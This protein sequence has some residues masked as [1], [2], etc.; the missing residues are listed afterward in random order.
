MNKRW[1]LLLLVLST[2]MPL[3]VTAATLTVGTASIQRLFVEGV[4][5]KNGRW[6]LQD[7]V[8][9]AYLDS[10]RTW[11]AGGRVHIEA[12]LSS[13]LGVEMSGSCV[14]NPLAS[15][16]EMSG[17]LVGA[18]TTLSLAD[19]KIDRI[20]DQA[21]GS[22]LDLLQSMV[23]APPPVDVLSTIRDR[24]ADSDD[25]P[26]SVDTLRIDSVTTSDTEVTIQFDF[27]VRAP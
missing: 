25:V 17:R 8:C 7:G 22:A 2:A 3:P 21:A 27:G 26:I 24:L 6:Y 19:V 12:R 14:G 5:N 18:G 10:P 4:F 16:I 1:T 9:Y 13:L 15:K 23:P 11:L 20:E